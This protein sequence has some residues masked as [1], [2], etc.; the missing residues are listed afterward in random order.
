LLRLVA[1]GKIAIGGD[2]EK[3]RHQQIVSAPRPQE[4][5]SGFSRIYACRDSGRDIDHW[6]DHGAGRAARAELPAGLENQGGENPDRKLC[7]RAQALQAR[8][9]CSISTMAATL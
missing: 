9:T 6:L 5:Q 7:K 2:A 1:Y 8:S 3:S 4:N